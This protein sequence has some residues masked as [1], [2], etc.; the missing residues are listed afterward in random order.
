MKKIGII[1]GVICVATSVGILLAMNPALRPQSAL[2]SEAPKEV[3]ETTP[4]EMAALI[5]N[6]VIKKE[7]EWN[8]QEIEKLFKGKLLK[9]KGEVA[10]ADPEDFGGE[11]SFHPVTVYSWYKLRIV[12]V[13]PDTETLY[14]IK[15]KLGING[16]WAPGIKGKRV[17]MIGTLKIVGKPGF[18]YGLESPADITIE[19]SDITWQ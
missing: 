4:Q 2:Q 7:G 10:D 15:E 12:G 13:F 11:I 8:C 14:E 16:W 1:A 3:L 9:I 6:E 5:Y 18:Y 19:I 17:V